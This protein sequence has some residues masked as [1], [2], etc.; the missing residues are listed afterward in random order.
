MRSKQQQTKPHDSE[1]TKLDIT[2]HDYRLPV[3]SLKK[4]SFGMLALKRLYKITS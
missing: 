3:L 2:G 1:N 4:L